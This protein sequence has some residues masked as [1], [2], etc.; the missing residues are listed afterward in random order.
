M[1]TTWLGPSVGVH[2]VRS[3][4]YQVLQAW[5]PVA[6]VDVARQSGWDLD[7]LELPRSWYRAADYLRLPADQTP[8]IIVASPQTMS[9][10][11]RR[12]G[13]VDMVWRL[14]VAATVRGNTFE[15]SA[16]LVGIYTTAVSQ[17]LAQKLAAHDLIDTVTVPADGGEVYDV[18]DMNQSRT[19]ATGVVTVELSVTDARRR[20]GANLF[21]VP[22]PPE[23]PFELAPA[24]IT[25]DEATF[26]VERATFEVS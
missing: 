14:N 22:E 7:R 25:V 24:P 16:D 13:A 23:D 11:E 20:P 19:L 18:L 1:T 21:P 26:D 5:L 9:R 8:N 15:D 4:A 17:V 6:V 12:D 3:A 10:T 2:D